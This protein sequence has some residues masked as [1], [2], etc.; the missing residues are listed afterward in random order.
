MYWVHQIYRGGAY[1]ILIKIWA[2]L[3]RSALKGKIIGNKNINLVTTNFIFFLYEAK[4]Y[5][6]GTSNLQGGGHTKS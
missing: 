2:E 6:L 3:P 1:N 5:V 4:F